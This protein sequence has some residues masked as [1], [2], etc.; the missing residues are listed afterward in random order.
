MKNTV[1]GQ[2]E[3]MTINTLTSLRLIFALILL[4]GATISYGQDL[5]AE[6]DTSEV[7]DLE[8]TV[9]TAEK[10]PV[11]Y[12]LDRKTVSGSSS[13]S[14]AGGTA[15]DIL[16]S[17]PSVRI[18][19][20][21]EVSFRGSTG[22]L[23]YVDG[24]PS[25]LEGTQALEQIPAGNIEDIEIITSPSASYRTDGDAGI[26]NIITRKRRAEG[27]GGSVSASGS[28]IGTWSGDVQLSLN[29]GSHRWFIGATASQIRGRSE[30]RQ[31]KDTDMDGFSTISDAD[32]YRHSTVSSYIGSLGWEFRNDRHHAMVEVQSG[33]TDNARGGDMSYYENRRHSGT[34][35]ND[36]T[37]DSHDRYSNEKR[38]AQLSAEYTYTLNDRGDNIS[39]HGRLRYD[40]YALE[41]TESNLFTQAGARYEGTRGYEDEYHWD[42]DWDIEYKMNYRPS[43]K[44]EAGYQM[45]SYSEVG[46]YSIK[47]WDRDAGQFQWQDDMYAPFFYRRQIHSLYAMA[48]DSFGPVDVNA[49]IRGDYTHDI[50]NITVK[51]ASRNLRRYEIFPSAHV[52]YRAPHDNT[53]TASYAFRTNRPGIWKLEPYITYEDYYTR[54]IGNP[55]I[56]PEYIHSAELGYRKIFGKN[57]NSLSL[58]GFFRSRKGKTDLVRRPYQPGVTL[59]SLINAGNDITFG[60]EAEARVKAAGWWDITLTASGYRYM[61]ESTYEGG[62]D[63]SVTSYTVGMINSFKAGRT[64]RIQFDANA[65]GP[66]VLSQGREK[67]YFYFDLAIRQ[68]LLGE[69]LSAS[70]VFHDAFHT[71]RYSNRRGTEGLLSV[72]SVRPVYPNIILSLTYSFNVKDRKEHSGAISTG[73]IFEG[74]DF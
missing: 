31:Q 46:D 73:T 53:F 67:G 59:D 21:G 27:L 52:S 55:D 60:L 71:A 61:F 65:L 49:G 42:Y 32:G 5:T 48:T 10:K 72:T 20:D 12:R 47:Y 6:A 11:V 8:G 36:A 22:F 44:F 23:V 70:L 15:V 56:K 16:K 25:M 45:T 69:R 26:I 66:A 30:F 57:R 68:Q 58:T 3:T 7:V 28:T 38:L 14:A 1:N 4:S 29:R 39:A 17:M 19:A 13:L 74:K 63:G 40:W 62:R 18:D 43:G 37:Y 35:I 34:V 54:M 51:D 2:Q 64:T 9:F 24:K 41:Y 33:M 50:M